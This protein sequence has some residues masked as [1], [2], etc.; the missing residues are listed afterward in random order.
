MKL[1]LPNHFQLFLFSTDPAIV[2]TAISAGID[3]I[4]VDWENQGKKLRQE[5]FDTQINYDTYED[6]CRVRDVTPEGKL[7]CR[8]NGFSHEYTQEEVELAVRAGADEIFLPMVRTVEEARATLQMI[9]GRAGFNILIETTSALDCIAELSELPLRRAYIGLNDLHIQQNSRN[10][11]V[12]LMNE[13]VTGI[14]KHFDIPLGAGGVTYPPN[15]RPIA[16]KY[17]INEYARLGIDFSF[18]RRT[19]IKDHA[20]HSM[21]HMVH[22]IRKAYDEARARSHDEVHADFQAFREQVERWTTNPHHA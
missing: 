4:I 2:R 6:L 19:F 15:G 5:N 3:G 12:P 7:I 22:H 1:N 8:I 13:T 11:F 17:L 20:S 14:R 10:I 16:S 21:E 18:L 9:G